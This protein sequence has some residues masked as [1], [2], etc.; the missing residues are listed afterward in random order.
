[1]TVRKDKRTTSEER[2]STTTKAAKAIID[3]ETQARDKKTEKLKAAR[4]E[5]DTEAA[6]VARSAP[7]PR[8]AKKTK[9]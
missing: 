1:V 6:K 2:A 9:P 7:E 4:L 3:A 8:S 5:R